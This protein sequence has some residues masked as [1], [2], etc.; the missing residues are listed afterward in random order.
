MTL[1]STGACG[2]IEPAAPGPVRLLE[3]SAVDDD[4][5]GP[6]EPELDGW[7]TVLRSR[8]LSLGVG[9]RGASEP[10]DLAGD[11]APSTRFFRKE[12]Q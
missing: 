8:P 6:D 9:L 5:G 11:G 2:R 7:L 12:L 10:A 1:G 3:S 4:S